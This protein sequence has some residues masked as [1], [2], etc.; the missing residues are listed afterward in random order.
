MKNLILRLSFTLLLAVAPQLAAGALIDLQPQSIS[1]SAE[2]EAPTTKDHVT[3]PEA[4]AAEPFPQQ[5][6]HQ[7]HAHDE[8]AH[9]ADE[10]DVKT[11]TTA[12][13]PSNTAASHVE[14]IR[15]TPTQIRHAGLVFSTAGPAQLAQKIPLFGV[16]SWPSNKQFRLNAPYPGLIEQVR[17]EVGDTVNKG[18]LLAT[19]RNNNTLQSY[20]LLAPASGVVTQRWLNVGDL[21]DS[22]VL[23]ISDDQQLWL[24]MSVFPT[25]ASLLQLAQPLQLQDLD[26]PQSTT[27]HTEISY[28]APQLSLGHI[29]RAR[30]VLDKSKLPSHWRAGMHLQAWLTVA[31]QQVAVAV[32]QSALQQ[33]E[34]NTVVFVQQGDQLIATPVELGLVASPLVEI[35]RGLTAGSRY[36]SQQ[37]F[38]LKAEL[39]KSSAGHSH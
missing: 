19:V 32:E 4:R 7:E 37:S 17:V 12:L 21:A 36:V 10:S 5:P 33:V 16:L 27:V 38:V 35:R 34:G 18:Q 6:S 23:E 24:E 39:G 15:L 31:Q 8:A 30:A 26:Q 28:I 29:T 25:D 9:A 20:S 22:A 3:A 13:Q 14:S 1:L 11:A 2:R